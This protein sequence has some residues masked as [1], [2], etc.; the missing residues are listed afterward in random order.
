MSHDIYENQKLLIEKPEIK[1]ATPEI[2]ATATLGIPT[3]TA[4]QF[5]ASTATSTITPLPTPPTSRQ[6]WG[7][8]LGVIV[9][10]NR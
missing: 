6:T 3:S 2:K 10:S 4:T 5:V 1:T 7:M 9:L 8:V